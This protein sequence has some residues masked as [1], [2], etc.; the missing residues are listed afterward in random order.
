MKVTDAELA[1]VRLER[2]D[3]HG[4]WNYTIAPRPHVIAQVIP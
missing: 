2:A 3:F 1:A 4:D